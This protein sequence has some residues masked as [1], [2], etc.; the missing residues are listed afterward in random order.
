MPV[1]LEHSHLSEPIGMSR[2]DLFLL[3]GNSIKGPCRADLGPLKFGHN[4]TLQGY[5]ARSK[6]ILKISPVKGEASL[7]C[8]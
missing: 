6:Q 5:S 8:P 2:R 1:S 3:P 7:K 4:V